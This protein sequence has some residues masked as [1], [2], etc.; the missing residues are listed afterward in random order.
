VVQYYLEWKFLRK[1]NNGAED[2]ASQG[3]YNSY[4]TRREK[5]KQKEILGRTFRLKPQINSLN[6]RGSESREERLGD[7][8]SE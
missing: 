5:L 8:W 2:S 3:A 1:L 4:L 6:M 7:L